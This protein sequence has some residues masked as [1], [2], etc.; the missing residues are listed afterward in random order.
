[1]SNSG[2]QFTVTVYVNP[3]PAINTINRTICTGTSFVVTPT[4]GTDGFVPT[5]VTYVWGAPSYGNASMSGGDSQTSASPN[6]FGGPLY[7]PTSSPYSVT[8]TVTPGTGNCTGLPFTVVVTVD[9]KPQV[10]AMSTVVC[11][12]ALFVV[13]PTNVTNG[14]VPTGTLYQWSAPTGNDIA[15]GASASGQVDVRGTL[16]NNVNVQRTATYVVIPSYGT[17]SGIS[18]SG[19]AFTVTVYVNPTPFVSPIN[20]TICTGTSFAV[21]PAIGGSNIIPA[22]TLYSWSIPTYTN[23]SLSGGVASTM[24]TTNIFGT[25]DNPTNTTYNAVYTVTPATS[26]CVG[27]TFLVTVAVDP[28]PSI[29]QMSTTICNG[30]FTVTPSN[31]ANGVVPVNTFYTWGIPTA[32]S[33]SLTGG[34]AGTGTTNITGTLTNNTNVAQTA[35]YLV[36]P[37]FGTCSGVSNSGNA[38][39]VTVYVN[40]RPLINTIN[41]T[42]CTGTSFV[43]TPTQ[44]TDGFVP[45]GT[46]YTWGVPLYGNASMS[47]GDSQTTASDNIFGTVL[48]PTN[49]TYNVTYSVTPSTGL[50]PGTAFT[51]VE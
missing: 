9:P 6:I 20:Q 1:V 24:S 46:Q 27:N 12:G 38:F 23:A 37:S 2:N 31:G 17:C 48:N 44:G 29:T 51:V 11:S 15:N 49:T 33:T 50:C 45:T 4:N 25:I 10:N 3:A 5:G 32:S 41:R 35:V 13:S 18:L 22:G 47:G 16:T 39:T 30:G 21:T 36:T 8:Y 19:N 14:L 34:V 40:P 43:I 42:T 7:N 26:I 28:K